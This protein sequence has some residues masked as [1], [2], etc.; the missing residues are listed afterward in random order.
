MTKKLIYKVLTV[1]NAMSF[2]A[3]VPSVALLEP[4][5]FITSLIIGLVLWSH[6]LSYLLLCF[7]FRFSV[8]RAVLFPDHWTIHVSPGK[9]FAQWDTK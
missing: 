5:S 6:C 1:S 4:F 7:L 3:K 8:N 2:S 9:Y